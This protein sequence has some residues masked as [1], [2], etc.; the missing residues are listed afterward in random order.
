MKIGITGNIGSGKTTAVNVFKSMGIPV[1]LAD[2][3]AKKLYKEQEVKDKVLELFG[4]QV[5]TDDDIDLKKLAEVIFNS[6][7]K[8]NQINNLIHPLVMKRYEDWHKK[9][10][11]PYT[12]CESAIIFEARIQAHFN[13]VIN[14]YAPIEMRI[15]RVMNRDS[16]SKE[17]VKKRMD[18]QL[19]DEFKNILSHFHITNDGKQ[20][21]IEQVKKI[22]KQLI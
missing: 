4:S 8:L 7:S 6:Q 21:L 15:S 22:N 3:E 14:I 17:E 16:V 19:P 13:Y 10:N 2:D 5:F 12:I 20:D 1:Y 11:S 18:T 9:Q